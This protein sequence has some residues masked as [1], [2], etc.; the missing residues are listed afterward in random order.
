MGIFKT[1]FQLINKF[2]NRFQ[3]IF[4]KKQ[5]TIFSFFI[6]AM[7]KDY[8]RYS[9]Q[10]LAHKT[11]IEYQRFQYFLSESNWS[12]DDIN[13]TCLNLIESQRPTASTK[14]GVLVIDDTGNPKPFAKKTEGAQWQYCGPLKREER[15]NVVVFSAFSSPTKK[16]PVNFKFYK[17]A[18]EFQLGK[19]DPDFKSKLDLAQDLIIDALHHKIKFSSLVFDAWFGNSSALLEFTHFDHNLTFITELDADRNIQFYHPQL[20]KHLFLRVDDLVK[21]VKK[22]FPHKLKPVNFK[23]RDGKLRL[24]WTYSFKSTLKNCSVPLKVV[25]MFGKFNQDDDKDVHLFVTNDTRLSA[26]SIISTYLLRWGIEQIFRE[27]KDSFGFDQYQ[28][29][30]Q[31]QIQRYWSLCLVSWTLV[32]W[33]K[34]HPYIKKILKPGIP[35]SSFNDYKKAIDSLLTF[36]SQS[37][38]SKNKALRD[39]YFPIN[40]M[41]FIETCLATA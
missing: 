40:S 6:Y 9:L 32:Y 24:L 25:V 39:S 3:H 36:S 27:L 22:L 19:F 17:P 2:L 18:A 10:S 33:L 37:I 15:C 4:S 16:F 28:L 5:F 31:K 1:N 26:Y 30:H 41:R 12:I 34:Q 21:V 7:C 29:R 23:D 38:L 14:D 11:N 20:R 8:K 13:H 35:L